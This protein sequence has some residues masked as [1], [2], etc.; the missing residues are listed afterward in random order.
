MTDIVKNVK[1]VKSKEMLLTLARV[2]AGGGGGDRIAVARSILDG[3][4]TEYIDPELTKVAIPMSS[5][6]AVFK[7]HNVKSIVN[8][9]LYGSK[10]TSLA[11]P[12][13]TSLGITCFRASTQLQAFDLGANCSSIPGNTFYDC[14]SLK[15]L[16]LR[17]T[18]GVISLTSTAFTGTPF[19]SD[20]SGGDI[21]IPK[22]L[23]D[24]LGAGTNDYKSATNWSA[25]NS[26]GTITWH[27]IEGS[28]YET[29]YV[30]GTPIS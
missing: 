19:A 27:P 15:T 11:F 6:I 22:S 5:T 23:Y 21:Y 3:T 8:S 17:R 13:V 12:R 30:D 20:G 25:F 7:C 4:V 24:K 28:I 2:A 29:Q 18:A 16:V 26:Y 14:H 1:N 10:C 9:G